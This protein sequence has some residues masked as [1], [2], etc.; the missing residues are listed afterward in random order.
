MPTWNVIT[1]IRPGSLSIAELPEGLGPDGPIWEERSVYD[2]RE[3]I[4][5]S[6][7]FGKHYPETPGDPDGEIRIEGW[8][9][10][11]ADI[12]TEILALSEG[13][14]IEWFEE[15]N[16]DEVGQ[17]QS[18]YEDGAIIAAEGKHSELVPDTLTELITAVRSH[19]GAGSALDEAAV[20]L[21]DAL[22]PPL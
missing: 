19:V 20:L 7:I 21:C 11:H 15:W 1:I 12:D 13:R 18:V 4:P 14:R 6:E 3:S 22:R 5:A 10:Y 2:E 8:S 9:K 17:S 16:E